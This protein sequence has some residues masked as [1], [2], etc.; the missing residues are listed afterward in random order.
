MSFSYDTFTTRNIGFVSPAE[1]RSLQGAT[2][3]V[4]GDGRHMAPAVR[5]TLIRIYREATGAADSEADLWADQ[6]EREHGRY[7]ADVFA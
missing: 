3:F 6:I 5:E 4:C 7:V 1:Q 2:V